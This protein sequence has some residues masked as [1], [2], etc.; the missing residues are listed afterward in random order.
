[1]LFILNYYKG[2]IVE[3]NKLLVLIYIL[4]P[5]VLRVN[6]TMRNSKSPKHMC[7]WMFQ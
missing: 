6:Q 4:R 2:M 3:Q 1:M 5:G 7:N